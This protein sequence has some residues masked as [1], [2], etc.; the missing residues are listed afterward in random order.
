MTIIGKHFTKNFHNI[1]DC[2]KLYPYY[3][4]CSEDLREAWPQGQ[5]AGEEYDGLIIGASLRYVQQQANHLYSN[6]VEKTI[7]YYPP[8]CELEKTENCE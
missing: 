1:F 2:T 5:R 8:P 7:D 6:I 4:N 3:Q